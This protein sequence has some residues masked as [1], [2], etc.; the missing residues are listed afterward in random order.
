MAREIWSFIE[1]DDGL[2][3]E[4]ACKM[5]FE[6]RRTAD[7]FHGESCGVIFAPAG[8]AHLDALK[9][10]GLN[11]LYLFDTP[12]GFAP[13]SISRE[14]CKAASSLN[15]LFILF[16]HTPGGVE[17]GA[18]VAASLRKG[19][20]TRCVD[21]VSTSEK[22]VVRKTA[23]GEKVH[24][25]VAWEA[26]P[27]YLATVE[28]ASLEDVKARVKNDP[29][30]IVRKVETAGGRSRLVRK[31]RV[32]NA[33]LDF[34]EANVVIGVG[35]GVGSE[36]MEAVTHLAE[37]VNGVV[38]GTRMAVYSRRIPV[39]KQIGTTGKWLDCDLYLALGISG[40]PQ[41]VMGIHG[42][43]EIIAVN[44]AREAPIFRH[45]TL[46]IVGDLAAIVPRLIQLIE[47]RGRQKR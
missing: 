9:E 46:G 38:G 13:E 2:L 34:S 29:L 8:H 41:H 47:T 5:A 30:I 3:D 27:P 37:L 6:A 7:L 31:W 25:H 18:R 45:A 44:R 43:R 17:I 10:Y 28:P 19:F 42:A 16:A 40:A 33:F 4:H 24:L 36:D 22:P 26:P 15:P 32:E 14:I 12:A 21:F 23:Y 11:K 1:F 39:E 20:V 35:K